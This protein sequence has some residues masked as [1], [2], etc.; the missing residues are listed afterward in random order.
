MCLKEFVFKDLLELYPETA[1]NIKFRGLE[2]R[3]V[4][5]YYLQKAKANYIIQQPKITAN[6]S[7]KPVTHKSLIKQMHS[8]ES[9]SAIDKESDSESES[10]SVSER[11]GP[12]NNKS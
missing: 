1:K 6:K 9:S 2:K 10:D 8:E 3:D 12:P 5:I 11:Q 7:K 4:I